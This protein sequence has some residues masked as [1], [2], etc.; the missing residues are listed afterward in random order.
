MLHIETNSRPC[1]LQVIFWGYWWTCWQ[2]G[3]GENLHGAFGKTADNTAFTNFMKI[4]KATTTFGRS[5]PHRAE[6]QG[7]TV[8][9]RPFLHETSFPKFQK[10]IVI[11]SSMAGVT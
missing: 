10:R 2:F 1:W 11:P 7:N 5:I 9:C 8:Y 4:H 6:A 3:R